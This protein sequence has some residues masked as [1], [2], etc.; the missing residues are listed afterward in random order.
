M[1]RDRGPSAPGTLP[2]PS[3]PA[4]YR[5]V[6]VTGAAGL[7]GRA[8]LRHL[9]QRDVP[10]TALVRTDPGDLAT[11]R[12]PDAD[13]TS[14]DR[15]VVGDAADPRVVTDALDGVDAVVHLAAIPSP[16]GAEAQEVFAT[17]TAT[18]FAVLEAAGVAGVEHVVV[19]GSINAVG[20]RFSPVPATPAYLPLDVASPTRAADPYALSKVVGEATARTMHRRH[21][22]TISVLRFPMV[23]GLGEVPGLDDRLTP[24]ASGTG[25][26]LA[27][28]A[29][30]LWSYLETRDA[31]RAAVLA[32]TPA[33]PGVHVA[34]VAAPTTYA[35]YRT[36]ELL[37]RYWPG[38]EVRRE[39]PGRTVPLDLEPARR[40]FGFE[41][42]HVLDL[43]ELDLP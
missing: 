14:V 11:G 37:A 5:R 21:G 4:P 42:E 6:L 16:E 27:V 40:L 35:P 3:D 36:A 1:T 7:I 23:G 32:L 38:V 41:A 19:A 25:F 33:E 30:D 22:T 43:P 34:F 18:T 39:L 31:A 13:P 9:A 28:T 2:R 10:V 15:V 20:L 29:R 26:D 8:V 24:F 17:N 12:G